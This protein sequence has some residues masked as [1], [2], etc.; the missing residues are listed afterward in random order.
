MFYRALFGELI[1][2]HGFDC[3]I[4]NGN[5]YTDMVSE[6]I[7][8]IVGTAAWHTAF[9]ETC[10]KLSMEWLADYEDSLEWYDSDIFF[11]EI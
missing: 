3:L 2:V 5:N 11:S 4:P 7:S 6:F 9:I 10:H 8:Y 1:S